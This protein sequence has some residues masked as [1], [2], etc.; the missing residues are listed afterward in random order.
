MNILYDDQIFAIQRFGGISRYFAELMHA[1]KRTPETSYDLTVRFTQNVYASEY[2]LPNNRLSYKIVSQ[3]LSSIGKVKKYAPRISE[4]R[5]NINDAHKATLFKNGKYDVFHPTYYDPYFLE[6]IDSKPFVLTV[7]D[8]IHEIFPGMYASGDPTSQWKRELVEK[9]SRVIAISE[10]TKRDLVR[11]FGTPEDK[12]SVVHLANSLTSNVDG[13]STVALPEKY[14]LFVG[15]RIRYKNFDRFISSIS[16]VL[17]QESGLYV[18]CAGG[19]EITQEE[20]ARFRSLEIAD[21]VIQYSVDDG[22]LRHLYNTAIMFVFPSLYEGFG[23]PVL[24]AFFCRCPVIL[25]NTSSF[26]EV[27]GEAAFYVDPLDEAAIE[28]AVTRLLSDTEMRE[29]LI[30]AGLERVKQFSWEKTASLTKS[31]Y[32]SVV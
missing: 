21:R 24:E 15:E 16:N 8:M 18:I 10:S 26:P 6:L 11:I 27:A 12:I 31:V 2:D 17:K 13:I 14:I 28:N 19:G 22:T 3:L 5:Q 9:A 23:M 25:S 20:S 7:Y 1:Y 30:N 4:L 32:E 29:G